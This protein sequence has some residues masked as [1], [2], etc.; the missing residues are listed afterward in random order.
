MH[1]KLQPPL[2]LFT[3]QQ[4]R[5]ASCKSIITTSIY[6]SRSAENNNMQNSSIFNHLPKSE[7]QIIYHNISKCSIYTATSHGQTFALAMCRNIQRNIST[8]TT[9]PVGQILAIYQSHA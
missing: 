7:Q 1:G 4:N 3:M 5:S 8:A 6:Y 9:R 2:Q